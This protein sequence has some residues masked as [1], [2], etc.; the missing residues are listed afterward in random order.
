M[1]DSRKKFIISFIMIILLLVQFLF[2][3]P[4][5]SPEKVIDS[6]RTLKIASVICVFSFIIEMILW[7]KLTKEF[8]SP[9]MVFFLVL[10]MFTCGQSIGW[11]TGIDMGDKDMWFRSDHGMSTKLLT[12]GLCYS[13]MS[14]GF[15]HL[16]AIFCYSDSNRRNNKRIWDIEYVIKTYQYLGKLL[17]LIVIPAF[18]AKTTQDV[19][20]VAAGG[21]G[22]YYE[23]KQSSSKIM[24]I[25]SIISEFYQPCMLILLIANR[26][27]QQKRKL[28]VLCMLIDVIS[29]LYIGGRSGAVMTCL[30]ILLSYHYFI[31]PF[32]KKQ[33][34]SVVII[35]YIAMAILNSIAVIRG[36]ANKSFSDFFSA[37][38]SSFTNVIGDFVGEIGWTITSICWT[39]SLVPSSYSFRY[40]MSYLVSPLSWMPSFVFGGRSN[41]PA[42][43]WGNLGDWLMGTLHMGYGPGY[44]TVAESYINFGWLG[45]IAMVVE[46]AVICRLIASVNRK[47]VEKD[48][49]GAT[50]Q[51]LII[52]T[53]MK[54]IVRSSISVAMRSAFFVL[55]PLYLLIYFSLKKGKSP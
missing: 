35:S 53:I 6:E 22:A 51:M 33:V 12:S 27:N 55:I 39:M 31:K 54:S 50:F 3:I 7:T 30:G 37:I 8:F 41:H 25:V 9:Y 49:F 18:I 24:T 15:F 43:V 5:M 1:V 17:L 14:V 29:A 32:T 36:A 21:Y 46:G 34:L 40:G 26:E 13:M 2:T 4:N 16:G 23:V 38:S 48:I 10:F 28:I 45:L 19:L 20:A 44:T 42:V 47:N 52:M 11:S